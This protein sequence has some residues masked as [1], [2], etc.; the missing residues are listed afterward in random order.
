M[1]LMNDNHPNRR[2]PQLV[3]REVPAKR[4]CLA[5]K[6]ED[7]RHCWAEAQCRAWLSREPDRASRVGEKPSGRVS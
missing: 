7:S 5:V 6:D 2:H 3:K 1:C 4:R